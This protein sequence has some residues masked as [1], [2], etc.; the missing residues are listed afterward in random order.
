MGWIAAPAHSEVFRRFDYAKYTMF[1]F[2]DGVFW[3]YRDIQPAGEVRRCSTVI[4]RAVGT[5]RGICKG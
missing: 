3:T 4:W 2:L 1:D 5:E